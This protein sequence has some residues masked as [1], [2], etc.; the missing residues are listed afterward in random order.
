MTMQ[1]PADLF[2]ASDKYHI[3]TI[4]VMWRADDEAQ[5]QAVRDYLTDA[6]VCTDVEF[7]KMYYQ[8]SFGKLSGFC[9]FAY[10]KDG[11]DEE[12]AV[13]V[14]NFTAGIPC[15]TEMYFGS[16]DQLFQTGQL[17]LP[18]WSKVA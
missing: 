11:L 10:G 1:S 6:Q 12:E 7:L 14:D 2:D 13:V 9:F 15:Q 5:A 16:A 3:D 18:E 17:E 8:A 4:V